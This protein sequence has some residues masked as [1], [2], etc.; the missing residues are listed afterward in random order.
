MTEPI[1]YPKSKVIQLCRDLGHE[2][3]Q[4]SR[5]VIDPAWITVEHTIPISD[6]RDTQL[7][8]AFQL[9]DE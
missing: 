5:I 1:R 3:E 7:P 4:V 6:N 8:E 2:P 9:E